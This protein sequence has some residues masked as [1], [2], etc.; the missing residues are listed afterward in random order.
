MRDQLYMWT[1]SEV[2]KSKLWNQTAF[3][4]QKL[5]R[6]DDI[7]GHT[8]TRIVFSSI[9][10]ITQC[11]RERDDNSDGGVFLIV[12]DDIYDAYKDTIIIQIYSI[13]HQIPCFVVVRCV[14]ICS[15]NIVQMCSDVFAIWTLYPVWLAYRITIYRLY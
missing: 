3:Y 1:K 6:H 8:H 14:F 10:F 5:I 4:L 12:C 9:L 2:A 11:K 15:T 7:R 13:R